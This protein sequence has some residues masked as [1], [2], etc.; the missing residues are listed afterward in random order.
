[1]RDDPLHQFLASKSRDDLL[2]GS[3]DRDGNSG[4]V[5]MVL[6]DK[7]KAD[8]AARAVAAK[9]PGKAIISKGGNRSFVHPSAR[10]SSSSELMASIQEE[11]KKLLDKQIQ[12]QKDMLAQVGDAAP[13]RRRVGPNTHSP[14]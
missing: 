14:L 11:R 4:T 7:Q 9:A 10:G 8:R 5:P 6:T 1:M 2:K 12:Q 13:Q 3:E